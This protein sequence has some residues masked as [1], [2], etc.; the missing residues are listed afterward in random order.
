MRKFVR[1]AKDALAVVTVCVGAGFATGR[2]IYLFFAR[3]GAAGLAGCA[4]AALL[5]DGIFLG[6]MRAAKQWNAA[7]ITTLCK[8]AAGGRAGRLAALFYGALLCA[9][10]GA[11]LAA[12]G[13]A[14]ALMLPVCRAYGLGKSSGS[15][16]VSSMMLPVCRAYGLGMA[17]TAAACFLL[18]G[19]GLEPL[20]W[21]GALLAPC[22]AA[23]FA[24]I[25]RAPVAERTRPWLTAEP[26]LPRAMLAAA[27]Y[28][29]FNAA[30]C[31]GALCE[32]GMRR[33]EEEHGLISA[34][35]ALCIGALLALGCTALYRHGESVRYAPLPVV[36][37][38]RAFGATGYWLCA[39]A[40]L[41]AVVTSYGASVRALARMIPAKFGERTAWILA[42]AATAAAARLRL[43]GIIGGLYPLLGALCLLCFFTILLK[44]VI[45]RS[46]L[47]QKGAVYSVA[48]EQGRSVKPN[49]SD[50]NSAA[51][52]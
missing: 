45:V 7:E 21:V 42:L 37:L 36:A 51:S 3:Y 48:S 16:T 12:T 15:S 29:S 18:R 33:N 8:R 5:A 27:C 32:I 4:A 13:E 10:G 52:P 44:T 23:L 38:S 31:T 34:Q 49:G 24:M 11:M 35:A 6:A 26:S 43:D 41:A 47:G 50:Q 14:F 1:C 9:A 25:L 46:R 39:A 30:F 40:L 28:A 17:L 22:C 20:A 2:E 19:C